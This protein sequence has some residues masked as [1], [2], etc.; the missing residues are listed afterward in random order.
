MLAQ[1]NGVV[2][3]KKGGEAIERRDK[4]SEPS[5]PFWPQTTKCWADALAGIDRSGPPADPSPLCTSTM[6]PDPGLFIGVASSERQTQYVTTW[7]KNRAAFMVR[8]QLG[9][10][11]ILIKNWRMLLNVDSMK[12]GTETRTSA[13]REVVEKLL[14]TVLEDT[15]TVDEGAEKKLEWNGKEWTADSAANAALVKEV[16]WELSE[17]NFRYELSALDVRQTGK[18]RLTE[19]LM[20]LGNEQDS[21]FRVS[22]GK[23]DTGLV[24][25]DLE[26]HSE[27][28]RSF[29][30]LMSTWK[31]GVGV[32]AADRL[33]STVASMY[34]QTFFDTF[35][36]PPILPRGLV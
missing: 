21:I 36:R 26:T 13:T 24:S 4:F 30:K 11:P 14:E 9:G 7:L 33:E 20:A 17:L 23:V 19:I 27:R 8:P 34:C 25:T 16:L 10:Q 5:H 32:C 18:E 2:D 15:M 6:Y 35:G 12:K 29:H 31:D 28:L 22:V 3:E 1:L